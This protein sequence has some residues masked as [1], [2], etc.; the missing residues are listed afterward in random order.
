MVIATQKEKHYLG[1]VTGIG[2]YQE[3]GSTD[4]EASARL[5]TTFKS[6]KPDYKS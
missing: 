5:T 2:M 4:R 6:F 1:S 3:P